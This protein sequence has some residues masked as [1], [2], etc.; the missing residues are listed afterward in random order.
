MKKFLTAFICI[1]SFYICG[2]CFGH[3]L[4]DEQLAEF[5]EGVRYAAKVVADDS[6]KVLLQSVLDDSNLL[7]N[8]TIFERVTFVLGRVKLVVLFETYLSKGIITDESN[9]E[10]I[11][12]WISDQLVLDDPRVRK[13]ANEVLERIQERI[14]KG[15]LLYLQ[16]QWFYPLVEDPAKREQVEYWL[17]NKLLLYD[18]EEQKKVEQFISELLAP[19]SDES[20]GVSKK[21]K[22]IRNL[23][24][25]AY[26][27]YRK[28]RCVKYI[29]DPVDIGWIGYLD[30][31]AAP[32]YLISKE[33]ERSKSQPTELFLHSV[34]ENLPLRVST[35]RDKW[36]FIVKDDV[37]E[38]VELQAGKL[39][40]DWLDTIRG[41][42]RARAA[43][44]ALSRGER[45][46]F[47]KRRNDY[48]KNM[49]KDSVKRDGCQRRII[50]FYNT[51]DYEIDRIVEASVD[52]FFDEK[53]VS[54]ARKVL[55][56]NELVRFVRQSL[57]LK[58]LPTYLY[59]VTSNY[60]N[61]VRPPQ[62]PLPPPLDTDIPMPPPVEEYQEAARTFGSYVPFKEAEKSVAYI[63][64]LR[65][66]AYLVQLMNGKLDKTG[67]GNL[68]HLRDR[69][70]GLLGPNAIQLGSDLS[71]P[72]ANIAITNEIKEQCG[73]RGPFL[74]E[75]DY[76]RPDE[77]KWQRHVSKETI[78]YVVR[79]FTF[80]CLSKVFGKYRSKVTGWI[81]GKIGKFVDFLARRGWIDSKWWNDMKDF[82]KDLE[83]NMPLPL[84]AAFGIMLATFY[85]SIQGTPKKMTAFDIQQ[86][87]MSVR[88]SGDM[89][90]I[91]DHFL[92]FV[93]GERLGNMLSEKSLDWLTENNYVPEE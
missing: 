55:W 48:Y 1:C 77:E 37:A 35:W 66:S 44:N 51:F 58:I 45:K 29:A 28:A 42:E 18:I 34:F 24:L 15:D 23:C 3:D 27:A 17:N 86:A 88:E 10:Q 91:F 38:F 19:P 5:L 56:K 92:A 11:E 8:D 13:T 33:W 36:H 53:N 75:A 4:S 71:I 2:L 93:I 84:G 79:N 87:W 43:F 68:D 64:Q 59:W 26:T 46:E 14:Q 41:N 90:S 6:E 80:F 67:K 25:I 52:S 49:L 62:V 61:P 65:L 78:A 73:G 22:F 20:Q 7:Q 60:F 9:V 57:L 32:A 30:H 83:E 76:F 74:R 40:E 63:F 81:S 21:F 72:R 70:W 89:F 82:K 69:T 39:T 16:L 50:D 47:I 85:L 31:L 12:E 54:T